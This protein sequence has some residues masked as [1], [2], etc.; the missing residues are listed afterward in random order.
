MIVTLSP[1]HA[2]EISLEDVL[3]ESSAMLQA[4]KPSEAIEF[5]TQQIDNFGAQPEILN[6]LAIAHIGNNEPAKALA[7]LNDI[8][9]TDPML[10]IIVHNIL[11]MELA[12]AGA[13]TEQLNPI[14][15]VQPVENSEQNSVKI[16]NPSASKTTETTPQNSDSTDPLAKKNINKSLR[17]NALTSVLQSWASAWSTKDYDRYISH[18]AKSFSPSDGLSRANWL[19]QRKDRLS[20]PGDIKVLVSNLEFKDIAEAPS[21]EFDQAYSS[22]TYRD[23]T[24][25]RISFAKDSGRWKIS[26]EKTIKTY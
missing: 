23:K 2:D 10:S 5:L 20:R 24:R 12:A 9:D 7:L 3:Q 6:N 25:K 15:F 18:Y 21:V 8:I 26:S 14:L 22:K 1:L 13:N 4:G 11:E 19:N 17:E 16:D